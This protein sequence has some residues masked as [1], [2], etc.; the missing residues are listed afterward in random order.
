MKLICTHEN[1][2][3]GLGITARVSG[4]SSTLPVLNNIL[5]KTDKGILKL[6][7]TNLEIGVN[8]WVR[9]KVE[10]EGGVSVPA[11]TFID[12]VNNLPNDKITLTL[13]NNVLLIEA[14]GYKTKIKGLPMDE[15]PLI[16][17]ID[18]DNAIEIPLKEMRAAISQVSFAAAFSETQ[19]E[20]SGILLALEDGFIKVVA[21]DRYRLAEK[22]IKV[23]GAGLVKQLIIPNKAIQELYKVLSGSN[24]DLVKIFVSQNQIMFKTEETEIT[25]RLIDGQY[26]DYKQ[27]IPDSFNTEIQCQTSD[28]VSAMRTAG[29]FTQSGNNVN[30][31]FSAPNNLVAYSASGELGESKVEV[32]ANVSGQDGKIIFNHR[33]IL[34]CLGSIGTENIIIKII[35]DNSPAVI[36]SKE[37]PGYIYLVMPIKI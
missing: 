8:T 29:I 2:K 22:V 28:V 7:S 35:N 5:L 15:F 25:S 27:I 16:P 6:S 23:V 12:L 26:P 31:E 37:L 14:D 24:D 34:D 20:I 1:L 13:D 33:Y 17:E 21:T 19:P 30:L 3:K 9:C 32:P 11:K 36:Q 10:E 4:S 18:Q